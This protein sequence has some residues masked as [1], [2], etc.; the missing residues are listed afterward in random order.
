M[1]ALACVGSL[2]KA[3]GPAMEE[4]V[5]GLLDVMFSAGLT[6]TLVEALESI[7]SRY[8]FVHMLVSFLGVFCI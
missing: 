1:E 2:A 6:P 7:V 3:M 5:R 4:H 8:S